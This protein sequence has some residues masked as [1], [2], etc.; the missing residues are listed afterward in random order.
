MPPMPTND[1]TNVDQSLL[2][3]Y[4]REY[5]FLYILFCHALLIRE[6]ATQRTTIEKWIGHEEE[7]SLIPRGRGP[8]DKL[9]GSELRDTKTPT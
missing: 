6:S 7:G 9:K 5:L 4:P 8:L 3:C 2:I 1:T